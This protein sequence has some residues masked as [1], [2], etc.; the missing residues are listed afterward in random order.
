M[1]LPLFPFLGDGEVPMSQAPTACPLMERI[2]FEFRFKMILV[3]IH[4]M[5]SQ[6]QPIQQQD[7]GEGSTMIHF[8]TMFSVT[9]V[10]ALK[11]TP[12]VVTTLKMRRDATNTADGL[13]EFLCNSPHLLRLL[14]SNTDL[15]IH[16]LDIHQRL[17]DRWIRGDDNNNG[18]LDH[19]SRKSGHAATSARPTWLSTTTRLAPSKPQL[20]LVSFSDTFSH[21]VDKFRILRS[22]DSNI[23]SLQSRS[24]EPSLCMRL[25]G[26]LCFLAGLGQLRRLR[27]GFFDAK[28]QCA[29]SDLTGWSLLDTHPTPRTS[30]VAV[31]D[32]EVESRLKNVNLL[33]DVTMM[34]EE[35]E[36]NDFQTW[37]RLIK[38]GSYRDVDLLWPVEEEYL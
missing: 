1:T 17:S 31:V 38:A 36:R 32:R 25:E 6:Q 29:P 15:S 18:N 8:N 19:L 16:H 3:A 5:S 10:L 21:C 28:L 14:P 13:N 27:V 33:V 12:N 7:L 4:S 9:L 34:L 20:F 24:Q 11:I 35:I 2:H 26:G 37:P 23:F 30:V 22:M